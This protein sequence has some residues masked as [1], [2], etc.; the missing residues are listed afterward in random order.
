MLVSSVSRTTS[1]LVDDVLEPCLIVIIGAS[2]DLVGRKLLPALF[3]LYVQGGLP[4]PFTILG[5][6]RTKMRDEDWRAMAKEAAVNSAG[7][8]GVR[9]EVFSAN[10]FYR[11]LEYAE[12]ASFDRLAGFVKELDR[13]RGTWGNR[14]FYL[15]IPPTLYETTAQNLGRAGLSD[16]KEG[17]VGLV[18]GRCGKAFRP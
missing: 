5:C 1:S 7:M 4:N 6:S 17:W 10:L 2:G 16:R 18:K 11:E 12:S 15:A 9:W 8:D 14:I 13:S 3:S